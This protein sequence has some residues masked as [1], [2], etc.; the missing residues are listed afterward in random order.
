MNERPE[1]MMCVRRPRSDEYHKTWCGKTVDGFVFS[2]ADHAL[3]A[4]LDKSRFRVCPECSAE[5]ARVI[6]EA[7]WSE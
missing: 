7:R 6:L 3:A 2:D 4:A 5:M 1:F